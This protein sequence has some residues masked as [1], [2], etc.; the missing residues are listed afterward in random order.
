[1]ARKYH[2]FSITLHDRKRR[3][4]FTFHLGETVVIGRFWSMFSGRLSK[5]Y[6][7]ITGTEVGKKISGWL[8][9]QQEKS[10]P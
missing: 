4:K 2:R 6:P 8:K 5:A 10:L 1:M 9:S 7:E 3:E